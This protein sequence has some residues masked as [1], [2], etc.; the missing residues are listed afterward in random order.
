MY[1]S[2]DH[3]GGILLAALVSGPLLVTTSG[4]AAF[5]LMLPRPIP[6]D[7]G[8]VL[9][10]PI[11]LGYSLIPGM[12]LGLLIIAF[13]ALLMKFLA[14][15]V[16]LARSAASWTCAGALSGLGIACALGTLSDAPMIAFGLIVTSAVCG[17]LCQ[18]RVDWSEDY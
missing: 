17:W 11:V 18:W 2:S 7:P 6:V 9:M 13:G 10:V 16:A 8:A 5:V 3:A 1:K 15:H 12:T 14:L 4:F